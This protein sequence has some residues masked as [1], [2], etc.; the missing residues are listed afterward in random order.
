PVVTQILLHVTGFLSHYW[1]LIVGG[2]IG[3]FFSLQRYRATRVGKTQFDRAFLLLPVLGEVLLKREIS[4]FSRTLGALLRNGV[5]ILT[6]LDIAAEVTGN[7]IVRGEI[8]KLP[9]GIAEGK[10]ISGTLRNSVLFP[11]VVINM[12]AI[13]EETGNLPGVLLKVAETYESQV[14]RSVKTLTSII[15]P[16]IILAMGLIVGFIVIAMLLPIFELDPTGG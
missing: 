14:D 6:A 8:K 4:R 16:I 15:E 12:I 5:P 11:P 3:I 2:G 7:E 10:G 13:G 1:Y 9:E